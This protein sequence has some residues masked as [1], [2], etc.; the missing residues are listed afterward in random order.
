M[1]EGGR[2]AQVVERQTPERE[3]QGWSPT[4]AVKCPWAR[5]FNLPK[6][7]VYTQEA[8]AL[9]QNDWKIVDRDVKQKTKPKPYAGFYMTRHIYLYI[10]YSLTS[11]FISVLHKYVLFATKM[12]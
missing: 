2:V 10:Q 12:H 3:V 5:H 4:T 8:V 1:Q 6:V 11:N 7:L 9:S